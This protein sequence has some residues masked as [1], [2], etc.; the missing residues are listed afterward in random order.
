MTLSTI[1]VNVLL[2]L[3]LLLQLQVVVVVVVVL[4]INYPIYHGTYGLHQV[5]FNQVLRVISLPLIRSFQ[6]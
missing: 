1:I 5:I 3:L 2:L 4:L 6:L